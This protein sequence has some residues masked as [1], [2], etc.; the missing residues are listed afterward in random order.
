MLKFL[1][2][3]VVSSLII[4]G[5]YLGYNLYSN[6]MHNNTENIQATTQSNS[7]TTSPVT[8]QNN[9]QP[10]PQQSEKY[11]APTR[12]PNLH[13]TNKAITLMSQ[14]RNNLSPKQQKEY[15][16]VIE[17][18]KTNIDNNV[19]TNEDNQIMDVY[20]KMNGGN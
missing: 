5:S 18:A 7:P 2:G 3:L 9:T 20:N 11:Q 6:N 16:S 1:S 17:T 10:N 12:K 14:N 15:D 8:S 4:L 19:S 13:D